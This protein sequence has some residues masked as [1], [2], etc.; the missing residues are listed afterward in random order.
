MGLAG[1]AVLPLV[2]EASIDLLP[3][4]ARERLE[5]PRRPL[6]RAAIAPLMRGLA[7]GAGLAGD[8]IP[9]QARRRMGRAPG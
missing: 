5:L 1:R 4:W 9:R 8:S 6:R 2:V 3:P 7:L